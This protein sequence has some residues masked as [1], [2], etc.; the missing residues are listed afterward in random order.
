MIVAEGGGGADAPEGG[1][2]ALRRDRIFT[3][4]GKWGRLMHFC[5]LHRG[6]NVSKW[7][8]KGKKKEMRD[9]RYASGSDKRVVME[10]EKGERKE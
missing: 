3:Q 4:S 6:D 8:E 9:G 1:W 10:G 7:Y 2:D 5:W